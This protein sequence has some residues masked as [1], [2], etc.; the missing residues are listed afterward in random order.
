M[1]Q[2]LTKSWKDCLQKKGLVDK[3]IGLHTRSL[4][5][6]KDIILGQGPA[7]VEK[8]LTPKSSA[9][10]FLQLTSCPEARHTPLRVLQMRK[11]LV[12]QFLSEVKP[13]KF[14]NYICS[15]TP[16]YKTKKRDQGC[17]PRANPL[18]LGGHQGSQFEICRNNIWKLLPEFVHPRLDDR[19]RG[20]SLT[21]CFQWSLT[22][23]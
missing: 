13:T 23:Y 9:C 21:E 2:R 3:I 18:M 1:W 11:G 20:F 16:I 14:P 10:V 7:K 8:A 4:E 22:I 15:R 12:Q 17:K 19:R 6:L 5:S